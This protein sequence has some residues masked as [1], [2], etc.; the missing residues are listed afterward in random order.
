MLHRDVDTLPKKLI[1]TT[2][3]IAVGSHNQVS[4][5]QMRSC[6]G[7]TIDGELDRNFGHRFAQQESLRGRTYRLS[8]QEF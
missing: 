4:A 2:Q 8:D 5:Q 3:M 7:G 1:V 6:V